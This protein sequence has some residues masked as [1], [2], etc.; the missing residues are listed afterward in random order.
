MGPEGGRHLPGQPRRPRG[1]LPRPARLRRGSAP[2]T[3]RRRGRFPHYSILDIVYVE[4]TGGDFTLKVENN[5]STGEGIYAEPGVDNADQSLDDAEIYACVVGHILLRM[6]PYQENDYRYYI[7]N[8]KLQEVT[9]IDSLGE[10]CVAAAREPRPGLPR[11]LLP[12]LGKHRVFGV[13]GRL[14]LRPQDP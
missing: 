7:F 9:A 4:T 3:C 11:G 8:A 5:S 2:A 13:L 1:P 10:A 14:H 6:L 12:G